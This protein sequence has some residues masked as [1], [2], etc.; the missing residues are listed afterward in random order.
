MAFG[1]ADILLEPFGGQVLGLG[2]AATTRLTA[3]LAL[4]GLLGFGF[5]SR[6]LGRGGDAQRMTLLGA[7]VGLPAFLLVIAS[8]PAGATGLF[9]AGNFLIG[10]GAAVFG[11]GT[12]TATMNRA[13]RAQVGLALGA[14]G[15]V[16][17]TAAGLAVALASILRD[18]LNATTGA[19]DGL[20]GLPAVAN[21]YFGV[22]ALEIGF[23]LL[24]IAALAP[25][26][27]RKAASSVS[28]GPAAQ[29][30]ASLQRQA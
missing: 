2:V 28:R 30:E 25:M 17:A 20:W 10:F 13:P 23:L 29:A 16:Q 18:V 22:Y 19:H 14:W 7:L 3:L 26:L 12:L 1:M 9:L 27:S 6:M 4:G 24:A 21:G 5:A 8:A 15:A 11:H